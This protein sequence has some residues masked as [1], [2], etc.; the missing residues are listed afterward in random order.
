MKIRLK[1][2]KQK[3]LI[4]LA[5]NK[6]NWKELAEILNISQAYLE[7]DVKNE[8]V[9]ISEKTYKLLCKLSRRNFDDFILEKLEDNWGKSKGGFNSNG[10]QIKLIK[11]SFDENLA[12]FVGAVL[13][14]GNINAYTKGN[15]VGV[16]QIKIAGDLRE[17]KEYHSYLKKLGQALFNLN[18]KEILIPKQNERFLV[19][20]SKEL[21][22]FF[23]SMGIKPGNKVINQSTI[24]LWIF[25]KES[26]LKSCIRALIDTDGSIHKMSNRDPHL[27]RI[28][29]TNHDKRLL[30]D[31]REAFVKLGF[32]P[33]KLIMG[34]VFYISRQKEVDNYVKKIGFNNPKN[35]IRW[36]RFK[37]L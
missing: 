19:F 5:K 13:G 2:G 26:Y 21:V 12:E 6:A 28:K 37:A 31:A 9:L 17:D 23:G 20:Y 4:L 8:K 36:Q 10:S 27:L 15:K 32:N 3:R 22:E 7:R 30:S 34:K 14:D 29:F 16:Y 11:P 35:R 33:S 18:S 25:A 24:P 1:N